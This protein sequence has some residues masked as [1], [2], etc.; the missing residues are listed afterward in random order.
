MKYHI[1]KTAPRAIYLQLYDQLRQDIV[2]GV[3]AYGTRLPSK[4][5]LAAELGLSVIPV[6]HAYA[7]LC[8]EGYVE[9]RQRSGFFVDYRE[10]DFISQTP[11]AQHRP[12]AASHPASDQVRGILPYPLLART[13]RRVMADYGEDILVRSPNPGT[14]DLRAAI[15]SYLM[16]A[17]GIAVSPEQIII[18]AGAEYLYSLIAQLLG[19]DRRYALETPGYP[20]I[21][22]VYEANGVHCEHLRLGAG[23]LRSD[24][25]EASTATVLH[26]TPFNSAPSGI[27]ATA[28]KRREYLRWAAARDGYIIEDNYDS[29]LTV[30][31]KNEETVFSLDKT[32]VVIY[33][34][35]FSHTISPSFRVGYM[36]LP[37]RLLADFEARLGFYAC[38][39]PTFEQLVL[40]ELLTS[41]DFERHINRIRRAKRKKRRE[42]NH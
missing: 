26:V 35:T 9:S 38:T 12:H 33:L 41:G 14:D 10:R 24:D 5:T 36:V 6:E 29:E 11:P 27:T 34:N 2:D 17:N 16:R 4:R 22:Q 23:G 8:D 30:S 18:G 25:L 15:A 28:A 37:R 39:V 1:D 42:E 19:T 31:Q 13:M 7:L 40:A 20:K 21:R 3:Y 32:G